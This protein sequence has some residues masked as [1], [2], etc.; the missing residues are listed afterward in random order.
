MFPKRQDGSRDLDPTWSHID[1][2][3][4][5]EA[6]P[7][8]KARAIGVC[9]YSLKY[10]EEL[11][12]H[13]TVIPALNQIE[14]HPCLPQDEIVD[15]CKSHD[16]VITAYSPLGTTGSPL[17]SDPDVLAVADKHGKPATTILL[18]YHSKSRPYQVHKV[19]STAYYP[20]H[21]S[22]HRL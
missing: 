16:I 7:K 17:A 12:P 18:S 5:M 13:A 9:N 2:W 15:F 1:T 3:K 19:H 10:L 21:T 8:A 20:T 4:Q 14:N 22:F 11:L 6:L